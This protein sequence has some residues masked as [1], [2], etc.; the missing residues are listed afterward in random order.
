M[1]ISPR[2][3]TQPP[4]CKLTVARRAGEKEVVTEFRMF[5]ILDKLQNTA[6][7]TGL[8]LLPAWFLRLGAPVFCGPLARLLNRSVATSTIPK[9][10]KTATIMPVPK[11]A[12]PRCVPTSDPFLS[13]QFS[14]ECS[15]E[16]SF[17]NL[18]IQHFSSRLL[19][20]ATLI[21]LRSGQPD[22]R[23]QQLLTPR[24]SSPSLSC[25]R[26]IRAWWSLLSTLQKPLIRFAISRKPR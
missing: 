5:E 17:V 20:S 26:A 10:W 12:R 8:D 1:Q 9:Q 7:V 14:A 3:L 23:P 18:F 4:Q 11:I 25:S 16:L 15:S 13:R 2:I 21:N 6:T 22:L 19:S 24:F